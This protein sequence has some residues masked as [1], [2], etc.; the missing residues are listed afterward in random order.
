[1]EEKYNQIVCEDDD[2]NL[3]YLSNGYNYSF[4]RVISVLSV[5]RGS[6]EDLIEVIKNIFELSKCSEKIEMLIRIDDDQKKLFLDLIN[7]ETVNKYNIKIY[8]GPRYGYLNI[9]KYHNELLRTASGDIFI[10]FPVGLRMM[11]QGWD[12]NLYQYSDQVVVLYNKQYTID[13]DGST[14]EYPYA[15]FCPITTRSLCDII[16]KISPTT[17]FDHYLNFVGGR[18]G[19]T[20]E[21]NMKV[22]QFKNESSYAE[23]E[24][25]KMSNLGIDHLYSEQVQT[26]LFED[27]DKIR[28]YFENKKIQKKILPYIKFGL[29]LHNDQNYPGIDVV[30]GMHKEY[31]VEF[32]DQD[33]N[34]SIYSVKL[35]PYNYAVCRC[36]SRTSLLIR[37]SSEEDE[38]F[39]EKVIKI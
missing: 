34:N 26:K 39:W 29:G 17:Y 28:K 21:S 36:E 15:N 24:K 37:V 30:G 14:I 8:S 25:N 7:N 19:I 2:Y 4:H 23:E 22:L 35:L 13:G 3:F 11:E 6:A 18:S 33:N 5:Y 27:I 31:L 16:G 10:I 20:V 38:I 9:H 32:I 1:M 12:E